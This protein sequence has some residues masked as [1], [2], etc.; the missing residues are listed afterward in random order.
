MIRYWVRSW[1]YFYLGDIAGRFLDCDI[2]NERWVIFWY[3]LYNRA[4][5]KSNFLQDLG[6]RRSNNL[7][8]PWK[9]IYDETE[10]NY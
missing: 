5:L 4:M 2:N 3:F 10:D 6:N 9:T 7:I 1:M 8:W